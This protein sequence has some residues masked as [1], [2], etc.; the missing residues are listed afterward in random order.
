MKSLA[1]FLIFS[2]ANSLHALKY[3]QNNQNKEMKHL[4]SD[5]NP[6]NSTVNILLN[7]ETQTPQ[8]EEK[9]NGQQ[10]YKKFEKDSGF[11][12]V[13]ININEA[14]SN[15]IPKQFVH[16]HL[17]PKKNSCHRPQLA[18]YYPASACNDRSKC[19]L[20]LSLS[21]LYHELHKKQK[22]WKNISDLNPNSTSFFEQK[23]EINNN[24][25]KKYFK[26]KPHI[27]QSFAT[28]PQ[29]KNT[30]DYKSSTYNKS[31]SRRYYPFCFVHRNI[32]YGYFFKNEAIKYYQIVSYLL[33]RKNKSFKQKK[34]SEVPKKVREEK[35]RSKNVLKSGAPKFKVSKVAKSLSGIGKIV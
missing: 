26:E 9:S 18:N 28:K 29:T 30:L 8:Q 34:R 3:E 2:I 25:N 11:A 19:G 24:S 16:D 27:N 17:K 13:K 4:V 33:R 21:D 6:L 20:C 12:N 31:K 32:T 1:I 10:N 15:Q 23:I 35:I 7:R 5:P 22:R 14:R